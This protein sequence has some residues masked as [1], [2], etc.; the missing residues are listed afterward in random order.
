M[1]AVLDT[2][3]GEAVLPGVSNDAL[4]ACTVTL[5]GMFAAYILCVIRARKTQAVFS[6]L[7][8]LASAAASELQSVEIAMLRSMCESTICN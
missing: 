2:A 6:K 8:V 5:A 7:Q 3:I 1:R 4:L